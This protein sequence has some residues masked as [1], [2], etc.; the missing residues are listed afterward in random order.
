MADLE[1]EFKAI[2]WTDDPTVPGRRGTVFAESSSA[3]R[4]ALEEIYGKGNVY[5]V[6]NEED[7]ERPR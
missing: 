5:N 2:I 4:V 6:Y 1:R 3:A 7:A